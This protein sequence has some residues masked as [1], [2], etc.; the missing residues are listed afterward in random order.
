MHVK[1]AAKPRFIRRIF[2]VS[3][4]IQT[5]D[6]ET[7]YLIIYCLNC[8]RHGGNSTYETGLNHARVF[9]NMKT[10]IVFPSNNA[11]VVIGISTRAYS[12]VFAGF[13]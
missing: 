4:A 1:I 6:N 7:A 2:V 11:A 13:W 12:K 8:I 5:K 10:E 3:N 9:K